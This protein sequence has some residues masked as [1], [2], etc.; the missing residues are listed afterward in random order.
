LKVIKAIIIIITG[1]ILIFF[2][3]NTSSP[4]ILGQEYKWCPE[5]NTM[6]STWCGIACTTKAVSL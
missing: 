5:G 1:L 6:G 2:V 3:G 4:T